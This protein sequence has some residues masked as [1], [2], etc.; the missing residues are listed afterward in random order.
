MPGGTF[1][2]VRING[3]GTVGGDVTCKS[4]AIHGSGKLEGGL[5]TEDGKI[6]GSGEILG[7]VKAQKFGISG[8]GHIRGSMTGG[9]LDISGSGSVGE[10]VNVQEIRISGSA[11]IGG[12]CS[13]ESFRSDGNFEIDGLLSADKIEIGLCNKSRAKEIGGGSIRVSLYPRRM[14]FLHGLLGVL[15]PQL[16]TDTIEG[17]E[18]MLEYT[19]ANVVRGVNV[20]IGPGCDIGNVEYSGEYRRSG[21]SKVREEK[22]L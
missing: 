19:T 21:D 10:Q 11:K 5:N 18:L 2:N 20:T 17:D 15:N 12:D 14:G 1:E 6:S 13:A 22:K 4:F 7:S 9:S 3:Y 8:S 16:V